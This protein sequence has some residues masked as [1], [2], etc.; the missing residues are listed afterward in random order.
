L[1]QASSCFNENNFSCAKLKIEELLAAAPGNVEAKSLQA[2]IAQATHTQ[3][4]A[5]VILQGQECLEK[6][7][8][9]CA[10]IFLN[11]AQKIDANHDLV[12]SLAADIRA[13]RQQLET[14]AIQRKRVIA[15]FIKKA[16]ACRAQGKFDCAI[17]QANRALN[18]DSNN[19]DAIRLK[20]EAE[21]AKR[22]QFAN[23]G[24]VRVLIQEGQECL[25]KG[26]YNCAIGKAES[27]LDVL[28]DNAGALKLKKTAIDEQNKLK[29]GIT[30]N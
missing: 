11:K 2:E 27:A 6:K 15:G 4:V 16:T 29:T 30:I 9:N 28:P 23:Q 12:K 1:S 14:K 21:L 25:R 10:L 19:F 3:M 8:L 13:F 18:L 17:D 7:D 24:K 22:Q 26:K 20:S 5:G